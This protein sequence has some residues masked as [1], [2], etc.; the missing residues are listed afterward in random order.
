MKP[1]KPYRTGMRNQFSR[2]YRP[3]YRA[4]AGQRPSARVSHRVAARFRPGTRFWCRPPNSAR[5]VCTLVRQ[6]L[7]FHDTEPLLSVTD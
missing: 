6:I 4:K 2:A 5:L 3:V 7:K 1:A